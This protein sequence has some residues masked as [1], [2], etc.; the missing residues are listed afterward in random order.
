VASGKST[1]ASALRAKGAAI[2]D[3]DALAREVVRPGGPAYQ[4]IVQAFG[5]SVVGPDGTL[6][7]PALAARIFSDSSARR[8]LNALTHP[9]IRRRMADEAA[10]LTMDG[11]TPVIVFD[12]PLLLDTTDGRDLELDGIIVVY[13]D[14]ETRVRRL[15]A[16]NDL[17]HEEAERRL[18]AQVPLETK[19]AQATWVIENS[20]T[21]HDTHAQIERLWHALNARAAGRA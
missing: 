14:A 10:R 15:M 11:R 12:I 4:D 13:A 18:A 20:G 16:R 21:P 3:A 7:R 19:K 1:V 9:H 5:P 2:I 8:R 6:D 17:S